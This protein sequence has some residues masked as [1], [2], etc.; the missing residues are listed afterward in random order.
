MKCENIC[1]LLT[2]YAVGEFD[3]AGKKTVEKHLETC[4]DCRASLQKIRSTLDL[5]QGALAATQQ[6][7]ARLAPEK[8]QLVLSTR[9]ATA[10]V[11][12]WLSRHRPMLARV[13][14]VLVVGF[15][16]VSL[17]VPATMKARNHARR[18]SSLSSDK[19]FGHRA[20]S[21]SQS[22]DY[23][24]LMDDRSPA[25]QPIAEANNAL[26]Y[27]GYVG[28]K[29]PN[30]RSDSPAFGPED[31]EKAEKRPAVDTAMTALESI[32]QKANGLSTEL[33]VPT[34]NL[35]MP[36]DPAASSRNT[37]LQKQQT[38]A[39]P[40]SP[41]PGIGERGYETPPKESPVEAVGIGTGPK[42]D[43]AGVEFE[44]TFTKNSLTQKGLYAD[45]RAGGD[46]AQAGAIKHGGK[47]SSEPPDTK[48]LTVTASRGGKEKL[49][50]AET[51]PPL[52]FDGYENGVADAW[53]N[54]SEYAA[55]AT[56]AKDKPIEGSTRTLSY[57][58]KD[59]NGSSDGG[60]VIAGKPESAAQPAGKLK[61]PAAITP[62]WQGD[63]VTG[64]PAEADKTDRDER[65]EDGVTFDSV[66]VGGFNRTTFPG[67]PAPVGS[68]VMVP[69]VTTKSES[70]E[71][72]E[73]KAGD[74]R[75]TEA[76][77]VEISENDRKG[78]GLEW[79]A[80]DRDR[81]ANDLSKNTP[82]GKR[83]SGTTVLGDIPLTGRLFSKGGKGAQ[84][85]GP[86]KDTE[87]TP[88]S[89][90]PAPYMAR[91]SGKSRIDVVGADANVRVISGAIGG[92][93]TTNFVNTI[94]AGESPLPAKPAVQANPTEPEP[95]GPVFK[96]VGLNP[97]VYTKDNPF[98]TFA[99]D[100]D[101]ASYTL[102]RNYMMKG[103]LPPAESVRTEEFVNFFDYACKPPTDKAFA[104][105][106]DCAPTPFQQG[107]HIL[108]IGVE[109]Q[110]LARDAKRRAV[111]T[112]VIDTSGSMSE[113]DRLPLV[114]KSL[115]ILID[116]LDPA[117]SVAII[118]YDSHARLVL[119]RTPV[120]QKKAI[121]DA[122]YSLQTSGSTNLEEG[123][124]E[125]YRLASR[126]FV[127]GAA[128][129][130]LLLSDGAAN[131]GSVQ[132][133]AIL[134]DVEAY[135]KQGIYCSVFGF[136]MGTYNDDMLKTLASKGDGTYAFIDSMDEAK[137]VFIE[138]LAGTLNVIAKDAKIQ[139]E[140][141]PD[142]VKRYRQ[143]GYEERQLTK[144][145]F[146][147]DTV[148]AGEVGSGQA[149]TALYELEL[150]GKQEGTIGTVRVRY[151]N[152]GTG[153]VEEFEKAV[154]QVD[155]CRTFEAADPRFKLATGVAEFAEVLRNSDYAKGIRYSD[156]AAVLR[157]VAME[158]T[159]DSRLQELVRMVQG[160]SS[161]PRAP[162]K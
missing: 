90:T 36:D 68:P 7:P 13:A 87:D 105:Y 94:K 78:L 142:R 77:F 145:Q 15:V 121:L 44:M 56:P 81:L 97:I 125:G 70:P 122:L 104:I 112:F 129:R 10:P 21:Q 5:V 43:A 139:V 34:D 49:R 156:V 41:A 93:A 137:R 4:C 61:A 158:L 82:A 2:S 6:A 147:D 17:I 114:Q 3:A 107:M 46:N 144:A 19:S 24:V 50:V 62:G 40:A 126:R 63:I 64:L 52:K 134:N 80:A 133:P 58:L 26:S 99:M 161:M 47:P 14:A 123:M 154:T 88:V 32:Q 152:T 124:R 74:R 89:A 67:S 54:R 149:V 42:G 31:R 115:R 140:F 30:K 146:R 100:V 9:P 18:A 73:P 25:A 162:A 148:D 35:K 95:T 20:Q 84:V 23:S 85:R 65:K 96:A 75:T 60:V 102:A 39:K 79:K 48:K 120:A 130:V 33:Q 71:L 91:E 150:D 72:P 45:R 155:V 8:R 132:A 151:K 59:L 106:T 53:E 29:D 86:E 160:A 55:D 37:S 103:F 69:N 117:D 27:L 110:R 66:N 143:I 135:R 138:K 83:L 119:D 57:D 141:N 22:H 51:K 157:P 113:P 76:V 12:T 98:S 92:H 153:K 128:N 131:L 28:K 136:G 159:L 127:P 109:G 118:Q 16:L 108:K 101:T 111:L 1:P 38:A 11:I 116:Q